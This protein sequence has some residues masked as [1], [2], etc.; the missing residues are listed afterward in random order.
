MHYF[1]N[2]KTLKWQSHIPTIYTT[3]PRSH[4]QRCPKKK[5]RNPKARTPLLY[6][7]MPIYPFCSRKN[8]DLFLSV[9]FA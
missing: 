5:T 7:T 6:K 8:R 4:K 3:R 2:G 9:Y 1:F